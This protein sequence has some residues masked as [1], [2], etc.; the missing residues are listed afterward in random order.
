MPIPVL[1]RVAI[2]SLVRAQ[3]PS[4]TLRARRS[5]RSLR[6]LLLCPHPLPPALRPSPRPR[7]QPAPHLPARCLRPSITPSCSGPASTPWLPRHRSA[8][9]RKQWG[10]L[11]IASEFHQNVSEMFARPVVP[12]D[13]VRGHM[14]HN[15]RAR[16]AN[17][18]PVPPPV[19]PASA[20]ASP[21]S[22]GSSLVSRSPSSRRPKKSRT[23]HHGK[24]SLPAIRAC[25]SPSA[26]RES[27]CGVLCVSL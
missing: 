25:S 19:A 8:I 12:A 11:Q 7:P 23:R 24:T 22:S 18:S 4:N 14:P 20:H 6:Q 26:T 21:D 2:R 15:H 16:T 3:T 17:N 10:A 1:C 5:P 13:S 27:R 9:I